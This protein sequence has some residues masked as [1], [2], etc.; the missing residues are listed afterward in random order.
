MTISDIQII[1]MLERANISPEEFAALLDTMSTLP[2]S[3]ID[4]II[5]FAAG[6]SYAMSQINKE[7]K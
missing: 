7:R 6:Q 3:Q 5:S 2:K 1:K 4:N